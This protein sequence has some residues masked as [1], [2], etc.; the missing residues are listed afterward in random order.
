MQLRRECKKRLH[1][2]HPVLFVLWALLFSYVRNVE[3]LL[4]REVAFTIVAGV[5]AT[6]GV[7][8]LWYLPLR[9]QRSICCF[10]RGS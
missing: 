5:G 10:G 3:L 2:L 1:I 4:A 6:Q 9:D 8:R 7:W